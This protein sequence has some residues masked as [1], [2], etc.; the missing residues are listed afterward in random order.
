MHGVVD[1]D[2]KSKL[3]LSNWLGAW[4]MDQACVGWLIAIVEAYS[5]YQIGHEL[6]MWTKSVGVQLFQLS[7][8]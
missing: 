2:F 8:Q 7:E 4:Y 3:D 1:C 6:R 5:T